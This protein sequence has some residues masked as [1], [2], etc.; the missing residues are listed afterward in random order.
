AGYKENSLSSKIAR[1]NIITSLES[2]SL[3]DYSVELFLTGYQQNISAF[4]SSQKES[5]FIKNTNIET[6]ES[7]YYMISAEDIFKDAC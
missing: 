5:F 3:F 6:K 4:Y 7:N 2:L 1:S